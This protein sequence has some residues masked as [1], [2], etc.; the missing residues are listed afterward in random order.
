MTVYKSWE[1]G[2]DKKNTDAIG[3]GIHAAQAVPRNFHAH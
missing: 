2:S 3:Q 1:L